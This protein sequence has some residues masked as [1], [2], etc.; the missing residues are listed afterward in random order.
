MADVLDWAAKEKLPGSRL[1]LLQGLAKGIVDR[2][3]PPET[4]AA[5]SRPQPSKPN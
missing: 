4:K 2:V 5:D 1:H 3:T